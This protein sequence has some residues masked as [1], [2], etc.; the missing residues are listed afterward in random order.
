MT[1]T[2]KPTAAGI[3]DIVS[4]V[5]GL[6]GAG[7]LFALA[8]LIDIEEFL[9][10]HGHGFPFFL[11]NGL[12]TILGLFQLFVGLVAIIGGSFAIQRSHWGWALA[13][14]IGAIFTSFIWG[15]PSIILTAQSEPEFCGE[16]PAVGQPGTV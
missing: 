6:F 4:G 13:G 11:T 12:F 9:P 10:M 8:G 1:K 3:L 7:L 2:W 15:I 16:S 14:A 5:H